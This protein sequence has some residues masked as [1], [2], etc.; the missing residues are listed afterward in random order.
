MDKS[1]HSI[2]I[3][4]VCSA[5]GSVQLR[6]CDPHFISVTD[7]DPQQKGMNSDPNKLTGL[8]PDP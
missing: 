5:T 1:V 8:D 4:Y 2:Q 7:P 6:C 3:K